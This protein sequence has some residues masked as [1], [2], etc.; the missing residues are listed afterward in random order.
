MVG[1]DDV[2]MFV[3]ETGIDQDSTILA[4]ACIIT[5]EPDY[6][7]SELENLRQS[8]LRDPYL[9]SVP[10]VQKSLS[11]NG[12]HYCEDHPVDIK[13]KVIDLI[14]K[15]PFLAYICYLEKESNFD[16]SA[17]YGWYDRL[18]SRLMFDRLRANK[19]AAIRIC[20]EQLT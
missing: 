7:R 9:K 11:K 2:F 6:L 14:M 1:F 12:F 18:F 8:F 16:P 4:V 17:G 19:N 5:N 10:S 15:L 13:P 3:D 20:F